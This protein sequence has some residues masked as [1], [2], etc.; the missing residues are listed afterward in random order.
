[1]VYPDSEYF[2]SELLQSFNIHFCPKNYGCSTIL[3]PSVM[4]YLRKVVLL[5][6]RIVFLEELGKSVI[7][8]VLLLC[9]NHLFKTSLF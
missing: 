6:G 7:K 1:M 9:L 3:A 8:E 4:D 2:R 5:K